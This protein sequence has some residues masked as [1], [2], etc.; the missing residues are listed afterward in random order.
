MAK[1]LLQVTDN[2]ALGLNRATLE[3]KGLKIIAFLW[4]LI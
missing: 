3:E 2:G 1:V 4:N